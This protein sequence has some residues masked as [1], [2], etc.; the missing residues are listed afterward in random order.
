M[1]AAGIIVEYNPFHNGHLFQ[2]QSI[3]KMRPGKPIIAVM[4]G[5]FVQ[6]G[7]PAIVNKWARA[8]MALAEGVDLVIEI[9]VLFAT[10]SSSYFALG[11]ISLLEK[12]GIVDEIFFGSEAGNL[13]IFLPIVDVL[14]N[15][16]PQWRLYLKEA[17]KT[18]LSY[19]AAQANSLLRYLE[20]KKT[21]HLTISQKELFDAISLPNNIL[22][23][24]YLKALRAIGSKITPFT[25]KRIGAAY[26]SETLNSG[27]IASAT[28]LRKTIQQ[29]KELSF[30]DISQFIPSAILAILQEEFE[31]RGG[32]VFPENFASIIL[33]LLRH[34]TY[35]E[36]SLFADVEQGL[37]FRLK[38]FA[39]SAKSWNELVQFAK[40]R[41][42]P[43]TRLQRILIHCLLGITKH[44]LKL[45]KDAQPQYLRIL[46][47]SSQGQKLLKEMR[48]KAKVPIIMKLSP[49]NL[50]E[51]NF[52]LS[53]IHQLKFDIWATDIYVLGYPNTY[54]RRGGQDFL[55]P[56]IR[57]K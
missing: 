54:Q 51:N 31:S 17:L 3:K 43:W 42:Y 55:T 13:E 38:E 35:D 20:E 45:A 28:A 7:E 4:S 48:H 47:F 8:K 49:K 16:P 56:V 18:G 30:S 34:K 11:A 19:P 15:E 21:A 40:T 33:Y 41:R 32:F 1:Y 50:N 2:L 25:L 37:Q 39:F 53:Y 36:I 14:A 52:S 6:R 27:C 10:G 44:D 26:N 23:L 22:A 24:E 57:E 12:T 29:K 46:A 9:P 5:N